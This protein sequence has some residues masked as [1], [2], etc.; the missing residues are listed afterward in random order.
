MATDYSTECGSLPLSFIQMLAST[1]VGYHDIVGTM[2]YRIN[3][4]EYP[5]DCT[6]LSD[7][8]ECDVSHID[9]ERQLVENTFALDDCS[10]LAWKIFNNS[11][12]DWADYSECG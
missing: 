11:D 2:H 3:G 7:F 10:R 9:P 4:L 5:D 6:E 8:L 1:I 12:N